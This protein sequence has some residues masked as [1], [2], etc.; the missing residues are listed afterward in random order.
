MKFRSAPRALAAAVVVLMLA[1]AAAPAA[2]GAPGGPPGLDSPGWG[3]GALFD[4]LQSRLAGLFG[5]QA[6]G[7]SGPGHLTGQARVALEPEGFDATADPPPEDAPE[8]G[9]VLLPEGSS[10]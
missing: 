4:W 6:E 10:G 5:G 3:V 2:W 1:V 8:T 9:S 7:L